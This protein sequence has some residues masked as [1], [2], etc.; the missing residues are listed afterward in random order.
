LEGIFCYRFNCLIGHWKRGGGNRQRHRGRD[1]CRSSV[2]EV[3]LLSGSGVVKAA[4]SGRQQERAAMRRGNLDCDAIIRGSSGAGQGKRR[5]GSKLWFGGWNRMRVRAVGDIGTVTRS[6][7]CEGFSPSN[8]EVMAAG[9]RPGITRDIR[10]PPFGGRIYRAPVL[11]RCDRRPWPRTVLPRLA[12][13][14]G[15]IIEIERRLRNAARGLRRTSSA[16]AA[17]SWLDC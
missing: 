5:G 2:S 4:F 8:G 15:R 12:D 1:R 3:Q 7:G 11:P 9:A 14:D 6:M 16:L 13:L 10:G 17:I